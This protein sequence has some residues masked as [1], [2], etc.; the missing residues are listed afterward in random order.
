MVILPLNREFEVNLTLP[1]ILYYASEEPFSAFFIARFEK[2]NLVVLSKTSKILAHSYILT[3]SFVI[4]F[5]AIL[6]YLKSVT[7]SRNIVTIIIRTSCFV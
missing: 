2:K 3:F 7:F 4:F 5:V 1:Y 6:N